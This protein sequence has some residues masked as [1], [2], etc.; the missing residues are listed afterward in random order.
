MK[1]Q[2]V[3]NLVPIKFSF[4]IAIFLLLVALPLSAQEETVREDFWFS[5]GGEVALY[6]P[7]SVSYGLNLAVAY[8]SG[9]SMGIKAAWF[10]DHDGNLN[11][12]EINFLFRLYF[13]GKTANY[14]PFI[15]LEGGPAI[16]FDREE[17]VSLPARIGMVNLGAVFGWRF[18]LGENFFI[19]PYVRGGYPY[20]VGAGVLAGMRFE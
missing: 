20:L 5:L 3:K 9:T 6:S 7:T 15:H 14:G 12:M 16:F 18:L 19:E 2:I 4:L 17:T 13:F 10:F 8:G 11:V 1:N